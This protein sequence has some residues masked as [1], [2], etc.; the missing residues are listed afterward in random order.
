MLRVYSPRGRGD[1][2]FMT[3]RYFRLKRLRYG[4]RTK[5]LVGRCTYSCSVMDFYVKKKIAVEFVIVTLIRTTCMF[6]VEKKHL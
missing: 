5:K 1:D 3:V 6:N 2:D 4:A